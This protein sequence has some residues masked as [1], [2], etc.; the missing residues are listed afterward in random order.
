MDGDPDGIMMDAGTGIMT[1]AITV[2]IIGSW[3]KHTQQII[4]K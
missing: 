4:K 1:E 3:A 2:D